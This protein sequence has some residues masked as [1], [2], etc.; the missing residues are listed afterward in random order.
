LIN[1]TAKSPLFRWMWNV[2]ERVPNIAEQGIALSFGPAADNLG[3][4]RS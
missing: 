4:G 1:A 3:G 2:V